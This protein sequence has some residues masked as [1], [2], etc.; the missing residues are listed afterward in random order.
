MLMTEKLLL[1]LTTK[2]M[3]EPR[4]WL[5][6][7]FKSLIYLDN[8]TAARKI[9]NHV[10]KLLRKVDCNISLK[11]GRSEYSE[12]YS[13]YSVLNNRGVSAC[14]AERNQLRI[15]KNFDQNFVQPLQLHSD[16]PTGIKDYL[17]LRDVCAINNWVK[18]TR[19][20]SN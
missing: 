17:T 3:L 19:S 20:V 15:E 5:A 18:Y 16:R 8:F 12:K 14:Q 9:E 6:A 13:Q 7:G 4:D 1:S 2:S 11:K 10:T